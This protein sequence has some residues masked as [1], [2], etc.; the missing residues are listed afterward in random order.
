MALRLKILALL[1]AL[2]SLRLEA[3]EAPK[4]NPQESDRALSNTKAL[5]EKAA[6]DFTPPSIAEQMGVTQLP[7]PSNEDIFGAF[8]GSYDRQSKKFLFRRDVGS[9]KPRK[10]LLFNLMK[11]VDG[12]EDMNLTSQLLAMSPC[13]RRA[14][15]IIVAYDPKPRGDGSR[16]RVGLMWD[17]EN[18]CLAVLESI[19]PALPNKKIGGVSPSVA[20]PHEFCAAIWGGTLSLEERLDASAIE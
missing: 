19:D 11:L 7:L 13:G 3:D 20:I 17:C 10:Y 6:R 1:V 8:G 5:M 4:G 9:E 15:E 14:F 12:A 18:R 16:S 2:T